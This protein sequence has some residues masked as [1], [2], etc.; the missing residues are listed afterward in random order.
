MKYAALPV[1]FVLLAT[2]GLAVSSATPV[3]A[4]DDEDIEDM[5]QELQ[6][7]QQML[8]D[9]LASLIDD[10]SEMKSELT[11]T[12][13]DNFWAM[14]E[15]ITVLY[16][17]YS[18][19]DSTLSGIQ[20]TLDDLTEEQEEESE[21]TLY[22]MAITKDNYKCI[23]FG[24]MTGSP[25]NP[26]MQFEGFM[27]LGSF[28][29]PTIP[30]DA[31]IVIMNQQFQ[32]IPHAEMSIFYR[33][34]NAMP[35]IEPNYPISNGYTLLLPGLISGTVSAGGYKST[36]FFVR[37]GEVD[38]DEDGTPEP[39]QVYFTSAT[40]MKIG[41]PNVLKAVNQSGA[42]LGGAVKIQDPDAD[43]AYRLQEGPNPLSF[44]P[45][46]ESFTASLVQDG[47]V[48][49]SDTLLVPKSQSGGGTPWGTIVAVVFSIMVAYVAYCY[50]RKR[51]WL[52]KLKLKMKEKYPR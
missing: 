29:I 26:F 3:Q 43:P 2:L 49:A 45:G 10:F 24:G 11:S 37:V 30:S 32:V 40:P 46:S 52:S 27:Q 7:E 13:S 41:E 1:F 51:G 17:L 18:E 25:S 21:E 6:E 22:V 12:L 16:S 28:S 14:M 44:V 31:I 48:V 47:K 8:K 36:P 9:Q 42:V 4:L 35:V 5:L 20:E 34:E 50:A 15:N 19:L 38:E 23:N 33:A 39:D